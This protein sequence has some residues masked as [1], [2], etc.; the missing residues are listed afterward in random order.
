MLRE[1][2]EAM[3]V[4]AAVEPLVLVLEDLHWSDRA[5]LDWLAYVARRRDSVRLLILG[6]YRPL[7]ALLHTSPLRAV[8]GELRHQPQCAE[9]VLD[10]LS[11]DAVRSYVR[12]RC[13]SIPELEGLSGALH[14]RTGGHPLFL[15]AMVDELV[16]RR[17]AAPAD[18]PSPELSAMGHTIPLNVRQFIEHRFEHL[19][20]RRPGDPRGRQR[21]WRSFFRCGRR[22]RHVA[23]RGADR[24]AVRGP[25]SRPSHSHQLAAWLAWPD[26]TLGAH[27]HFRHALFCETAY[28]RIS[29]ERLARLHLLIGCRL[30]KAYAGKASSI[31]AELAVHFEQ[32]RDLSLAVSY[33]EQAARNALHRSAYLGSTSAADSR[34]EDD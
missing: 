19:S 9:I 8:L 26:G 18:S 29:P 2:A 22:C 10:Y 33:L 11:L 21:R 3:E 17:A 6:T 1:L 23:L 16:Q 31:A 20:A 4:L 34:V 32:A 27:Y 15:A 14:G 24:S 5:T 12:Q 7:E 30:E 28:A 13:G 25:D